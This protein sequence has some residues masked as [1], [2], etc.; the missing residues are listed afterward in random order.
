MDRVFGEGGRVL[1]EAQALEPLGNVHGVPKI[2]SSSRAK[3][4]PRPKQGERR[5]TGYVRCN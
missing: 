2:S 5:I 4:I 3:H 1:P